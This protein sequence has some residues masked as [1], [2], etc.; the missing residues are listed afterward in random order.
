MTAV[1]AAASSPKPVDP[2][3]E[4][5]GPSSDYAIADPGE[6]VDVLFRDLRSSVEGLTGREASRRLVVYG[7]NQLTSKGVGDGRP[8]WPRR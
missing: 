2:V 6:A 3:A 5:G 1:A 7:P 4:S 8:S